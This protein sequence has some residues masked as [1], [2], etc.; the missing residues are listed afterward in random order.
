[1]TRT[2]AYNIKK[3][4]NEWGRKIRKDYEAHRMPDVRRCEVREFVPVFDGICRTLSS[5]TDDNLLLE[6][7]DGKSYD[8]KN[9]TIPARVEQG[10]VWEN[11]YAPAI[12]TSA[13]ENNNDLLGKTT[14]I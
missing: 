8:G 13:W 2:A 4:R 3:Q 14:M 10:G 6:V 1:M 12:T 9:D 11:E 5:V 7:Y